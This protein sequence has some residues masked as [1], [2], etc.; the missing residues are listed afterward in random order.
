ML[1]GVCLDLASLQ[2]RLREQV[3][4]PGGCTSGASGGCHGAGIKHPPADWSR[5]CRVSSESHG[6]R[7]C[8][9]SMRLPPGP[10]PA[11]CL[12]P[13]PAAPARRRSTR[14]ACS[15]SWPRC[16]RPRRRPRWWTP[17]SCP[18]WDTSSSSPA[19]GCGS[20]SWRRVGGQWLAQAFDRVAHGPR[21]VGLALC[22]VVAPAGTALAL[23]C[24]H[25]R[26]TVSLPAPPRPAPPRLQDAPRSSTPSPPPP[27]PPPAGSGQRQRWRGPTLTRWGRSLQVL[28]QPRGGEHAHPLHPTSF[29]AT[30][31]VR[32]AWPAQR[33]WHPRPLLANGAHSC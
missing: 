25:A 14:A 21:N 10:T 32:F 24:H 2:A 29:G 19:P 27:A 23:P 22:S 3:G 18:T 31:H 11:R 20:S 7:C 17:W 26:R 1:T 8:L 28:M 15:C 16:R 9:H 5:S 13:P 4:A 33:P 12:P 6:P 30:P